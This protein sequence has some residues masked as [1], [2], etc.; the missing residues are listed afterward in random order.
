MGAD[1]AAGQKKVSGTIVANILLGSSP[2]P[3]RR[4]QVPLQHPM[5]HSH[6]VV[7]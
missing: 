1:P 3:H 7:P 6:R 4:T 2:S 5:T